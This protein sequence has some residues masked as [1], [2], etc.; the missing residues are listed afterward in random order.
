M[1]STYEQAER[2]FAYAGWADSVFAAGAGS[3]AICFSL[4]IVITGG[5]VWFTALLV[6]NA[7]GVVWGVREAQRIEDRAAR[8][9]S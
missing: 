7:F 2:R 4:F 9:L 8:E 5:S 1:D 3:L 6:A